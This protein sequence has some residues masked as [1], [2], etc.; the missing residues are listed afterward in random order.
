MPGRITKLRVQ[1]RRSSFAD[2]SLAVTLIQFALAIPLL[3]V[4]IFLSSYLDKQPTLILC[5]SLW[6]LSLG[7]AIYMTGSR[8]WNSADTSLKL[9]HV[10]P[11]VMLLAAL[12]SMAGN[13]EHLSYMMA[14]I[15]FILLL[16][17]LAYGLICLRNLR[18]PSPWYWLYLPAGILLFNS[19]L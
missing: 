10:L 7:T 17:M 19:R 3:L 6:F 12:P 4:G 5:I 8:K 18:W 11:I 14:F 2:I 1:F 16:A 13:L 15:D 9:F